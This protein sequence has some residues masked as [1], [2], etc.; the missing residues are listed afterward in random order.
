[1]CC[2]ASR[3]Y[4]IKKFTALTNFKKITN[5]HITYLCNTVLLPKLEY[6]LSTTLLTETQANTIFRPIIGLTKKKCFLAS[7]TPTAI[8]SHPGLFNL[9]PLWKNQ[10][11]HHFT[12]FTV[13]LNA[14]S[15]DSITTLIRLRT[16]QSIIAS[17]NCIIFE[18]PNL[19]ELCSLKNNLSFNILKQMKLYLFNFTKTNLDNW[20]MNGTG[21]SITLTI[22]D[23]TNWPTSHL[24][25]TLSN[26]YNTYRT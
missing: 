11:D 22:M 26:P 4:K 12:E 7:S 25:N 19:F 2:N 20:N 8:I 9:Q 14:N 13:R 15:W 5:A 1:M 21:P 17:P 10:K 23:R 3:L 18:P 6:L 16:A 24:L